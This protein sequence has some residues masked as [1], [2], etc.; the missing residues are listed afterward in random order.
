VLLG[1]RLCADHD[2]ADRHSL[3]EAVWGCGVGRARLDEPFFFFR[4]N[5]NDDFVRRKGRESVADGETDVRLPGS[6]IDGLAVKLLGRTF[7]HPL[8]MTE[9]FLVVGEPVE[10]T[11]AHDRHHDLDRVDLPDVRA[12]YVIRMFDGA[13]DEDV[14]AHDG[15]V[16]LGPCPLPRMDF[17]AFE[18]PD[19]LASLLS[20]KPLHRKQ[21]A[22]EG[23]VMKVA[24][25]LHRL[26]LRGSLMHSLGIGSILAAISLWGRSAAVSDKHR[27]ARAER[28]AIFI[29]LW[30][31]TFFL[32]GKVLQDL[33][34]TPD[35]QV[36]Q[37]RGVQDATKEKDAVPA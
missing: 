4:T 30:P 24:L 25:A 10:H 15:N 36:S 13:D 6:S 28:L 33:E 1:R 23:G 29:G 7:S 14:L 35:E 22:N 11:L 37:A 9:R 17:V 21:G 31:P 26:G 32:L 5:R 8:R 3:D 18:R 2:K 20:G 27:R 19:V 16:S 34:A 12:Q